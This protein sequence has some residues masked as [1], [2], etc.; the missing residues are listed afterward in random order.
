MMQADYTKKTQELAEGR[1]Q[2]ESEREEVKAWREK[3]W[4][5]LQILEGLLAD[6]GRQ[7][8]DVLGMDDAGREAW[9][10]HR[11][12]LQQEVQQW[13]RGRLEARLAEEEKALAERM[14]DL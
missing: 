11:Q 4:Q 6:S 14:P 8:P 2:L 10:K 13:Q 3:E 12:Q 7:L 1:K 5:R 9:L